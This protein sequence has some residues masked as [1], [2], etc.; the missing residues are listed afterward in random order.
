MIAVTGAS[1]FVGH[2]LCTEL[3]ACGRQV[4]GVV[5][6]AAPAAGGLPGNP[7]F[8]QAIVGEIGPETDWSAVLG[9]VDCVIHCAARAHVMREDSA[10]P[11]ALYRRINVD[12]ARRLAEQAAAHGVRRLVYVSSVKVNGERTQPGAPFAVS[13]SPREGVADM[14]EHPEDAIGQTKQEAEQAL[15]EV[16]A[17]TGLEVVIVRP[18]LV[19]GPGVK[20]N[21]ARLLKLLRRGLPL[22]LGAVDN[23]RSLVGLDNLVDFLMRCVTHPH[24]AGQALLVSDGEDLSTPELLRRI[25]AAMH[26]PA[27]L[28]PVP[29]GWLRAAGRL[30]GKLAE[31]DRLVDSLQVDITHTRNLMGWT[32]PVSVDVGLK[33]MVGHDSRV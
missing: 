1:G 7:P 18:P 13:G 24:V 25:A 23:R 17:R 26:R 21:L 31:I 5:R 20:G 33:R 14:N 12:G 2:A 9:D 19:Y 29:V 6:K 4:R 30:S 22:P 28:I 11:L 27:H 32:P 16:A 3:I 15:R 10:D 8:P